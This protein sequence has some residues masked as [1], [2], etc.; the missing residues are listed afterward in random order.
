MIDTYRDTYRVFVRKS[1]PSSSE[2]RSVQNH[3][4]F[5]RGTPRALVIILNDAHTLCVS[6]VYDVECVGQ[7]ILLDVQ[8]AVLALVVRQ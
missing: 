8:G 5:E 2:P 1:E 7:H 3:K 6:Q 4:T